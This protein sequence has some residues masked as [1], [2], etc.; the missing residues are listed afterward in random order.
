MFIKN[1]EAQ[2][3]FIHVCEGKTEKFMRNQ[4]LVIFK[5]DAST[6]IIIWNQK[7]W[8]ELQYIKFCPYCGY[9]LEKEE[10]NH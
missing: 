3:G 8:P 7:G 2:E 6:H 9:E 4:H 5:G 1:K 10:E